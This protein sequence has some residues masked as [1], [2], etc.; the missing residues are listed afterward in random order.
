[1]KIVNKKKINKEV[2]G[3]FN[4]KRIYQGWDN[5]YLLDFLYQEWVEGRG[6]KGWGWMKVEGKSE[7]LE[8]CLTL[9]LEA[10]YS[11]KLLLLQV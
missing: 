3:C 11:R 5:I 6:G 1:M 7:G 9:N 8:M 10:E 4:S 2:S